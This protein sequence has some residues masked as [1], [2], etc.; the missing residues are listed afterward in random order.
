MFE[1]KSLEQLRQESE[2]WN[3]TNRSRGYYHS[4]CPGSIEETNRLIEIARREGA[5]SG[6][7]SLP[8]R[9]PGSFGFTPRGKFWDAVAD[10]DYDL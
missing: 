7:S 9:D 3:K 1:N 10:P 6:E 5:R 2:D 8:D 4:E